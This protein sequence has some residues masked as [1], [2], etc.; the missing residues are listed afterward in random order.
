VF[1]L[2]PFYMQ[3]A[4]GIPISL[5]DNGVRDALGIIYWLYSTRTCMV[6]HVHTYGYSQFTILFGRWL[7][8][9]QQQPAL[10]VVR[11]RVGSCPHSQ[12]LVWPTGHNWDQPTG[13]EGVW[14]KLLPGSGVDAS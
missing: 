11:I 5:L 6:V 7:P 9:G 3:P 2:P 1:L 10:H 14:W 12:L 13:S 4:A 8:P